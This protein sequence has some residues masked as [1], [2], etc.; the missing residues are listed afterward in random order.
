MCHLFL[1]LKYELSDDIYCKF[2]YNVCQAQFYT[3]LELC[4]IFDQIFKE[5]LDGG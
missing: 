3:I 5:H 4:R 2:F 1:M